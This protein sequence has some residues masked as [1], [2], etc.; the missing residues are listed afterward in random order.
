MATDDDGEILFWGGCAGLFLL[1]Q[2]IIWVIGGMADWW[3]WLASHF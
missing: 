3:R 2:L 1:I